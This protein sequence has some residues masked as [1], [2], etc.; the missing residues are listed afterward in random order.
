MHAYS[1]AQGVCTK[2]ASLLHIVL[3]CL[4][5]T[6]ATAPPYSSF[7]S[8]HPPP[9]TRLQMLKTKG[10]RADF[11]HSE[12]KRILILN[13]VCVSPTPANSYVT[14]PQACCSATMSP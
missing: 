11:F 12:Q 4:P 6:A 10:S 1:A 13:G 2:C 14:R 5:P 7:F 3:C 9:L 8:L